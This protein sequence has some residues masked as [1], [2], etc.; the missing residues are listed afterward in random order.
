M[1]TRRYA[2][3]RFS[4][5]T[6]FVPDPVLSGFTTG[7]SMIIITSNTKHVFGVTTKRGM[8]WEVWQSIIEEL[9]NTNWTA[10]AIFLLSFMSL[11]AIKEINRKYKSKMPVPIPE[12]VRRRTLLLRSSH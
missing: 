12:Q 1:N 3:R 6:S 9:P 5:I 7:A 10:F 4:I 8:I 2:R 11:F